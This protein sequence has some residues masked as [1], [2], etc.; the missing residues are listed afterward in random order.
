MG[1]SSH[2]IR[3]TSPPTS[4]VSARS[5]ASSSV[6]AASAAT[7][8]PIAG[9][10]ELQRGQVL[11]QAV[12]QLARD[13]LALR[14]LRQH[15][16]LQQLL[17]VLADAADRRLPGRV[18][19]CCWCRFSLAQEQR[20]RHRVGLAQA[21]QPQG[22]RLA[23]PDHLGVF[24]QA[25]DG[26]GEAA[27]RSARPAAS[28][29]ASVVTPTRISICGRV[30]HRRVKHIE[31]NADDHGP[32]DRIDVAEGDVERDALARG[33]REP[34]LVHAAHPAQE[35]R[36]AGL[37]DELLRLASSGEGI[38]AAVA[39]RGDPTRRQLLARQDLVRAPASRPGW[40]RRRPCLAA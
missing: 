35:V 12:M 9:Q 3:L 7:R 25:G 30:P 27:R 17:A 26:P 11:P 8:R 23:L 39:D 38:A 20:A 6:A 22:D 34:A 29:T 4:D 1:R 37:A 13:P 5:L 31:R 33:D 32:A 21:G 40:R 2:A 14:L 28:A 19:P 16:L 10:A 24:H 18:R 36:P 15:G